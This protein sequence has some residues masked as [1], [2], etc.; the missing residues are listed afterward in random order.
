M[1]NTDAKVFLMIDDLSPSAIVELLGT[2]LFDHSDEENISLSAQLRLAY[3]NGD[4]EAEEII[5]AWND[6][7]WNGK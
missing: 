2:R 3:E 4:I 1:E 6:D 7:T 5:A